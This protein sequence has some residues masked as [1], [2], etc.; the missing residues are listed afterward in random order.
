VL[1]CVLFDFNGVLV[2]DERIHMELFQRILAEH[3]IVLTEEDYFGKYFGFSDRDLFDVVLEA[4]SPRIDVN[5]LIARKAEM[6]MARVSSRSIAFPGARACV[7]GFS[8]AYL[9]GVVSGAL[10][11]EIEWILENEGM[12]RH[13]CLILGA[14]DVERGK[15][16]PEGFEK[17][18]EGINGLADAALLPVLA[19][20]CLVIEDSP[21]GV[22]AARSL[23][24]RCAGVTGSVGREE[25]GEAE[26]VV[27][28][29]EEITP[30]RALPL[31][32]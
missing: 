4:G 23:G 30:A 22:H 32:E 14:E 3:G 18:L 19:S 10:R 1:K 21:G 5:E 16:D 15:P 25:L 26:I 27:D 2:D 31:F 20:E 29:I 12:L 8:D 6:Y 28:R 7:Q 17:A 24:M 13:F 9:L 11:S